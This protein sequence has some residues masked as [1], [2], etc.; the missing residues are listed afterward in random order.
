M[1]LSSDSS[2]SPFVTRQ[3]PHSNQA[4]KVAQV[5]ASGQR[6]HTEEEGKMQAPRTIGNYWSCAFKSE[7]EA[8]QEKHTHTE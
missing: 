8:K 6:G 3:I 7:V 5:S 2:Q 1:P 4:S